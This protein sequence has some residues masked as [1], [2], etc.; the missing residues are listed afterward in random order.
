MGAT[1]KIQTNNMLSTEYDFS[2]FL[3]GDNSFIQATAGSS[4]SLLEGM[5]MGRISA[6]GLVIPCVHGATDGS[7]Y[8]V[9]IAII[10]QTVVS[11][12][13]E[14]NLVNKGRVAVS[15]I[16]F[17]TATTLDS[18]VG[19]RRLRDWINDL[20]IVLSSGTELTEYD[21]S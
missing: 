13:T 12:T 14:V 5:V 19:D 1:V 2:K 7:Q 4:T 17:S 10:D 8:P 20:G 9:G 11:S 21:N 6:S 16:N 15:K 3:L 18:V